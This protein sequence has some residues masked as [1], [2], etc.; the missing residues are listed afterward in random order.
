M[1]RMRRSSSRPLENTKEP[2]G[3]LVFSPDA[4][5]QLSK[6]RAFDQRRLVDAI[7]QQLVEE[8]PRAKTR[9]KFELDPS[10]ETADYELRVGDLRVLYRVEEVED[11]PRVT[12]AI[13]GR[14]RGN[15]LIVEGEEFPL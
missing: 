12:V 14:K 15:K 4:R 2:K 6:L 5:R 11:Q 13:I 1:A 8:D 3:E 10:A 9:N 7:R